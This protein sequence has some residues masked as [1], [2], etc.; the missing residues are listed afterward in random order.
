MSAGV[1]RPPVLP[2]VPR[3]E[4]RR[5]AER[6]ERRRRR[7]R[8]AGLAVLALVPLGVLAWL[9]LSSPLLQVRAVEVEGNRR[10][11]TAAVVTTAGVELGTALARVDTSAVRERVAALAPVADVEVH[12]TWP[13]T[14][15]VRVQERVGVAV[16]DAGVPGRWRLVD[17]TGTAFATVAER[18]PGL[19][20]LS[21]GPTGPAP[22]DRATSAGL[23][24]LGDLPAVLHERVETVTATSPTTVTLILDEG[25]TVVWGEAQDGARKAAVVQALLARRGRTL[26]VSSPDV[27]VVR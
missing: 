22:D 21:V 7:L 24:V 10:L 23:A 11:S 27:A 16:V 3:L 9:L 13:G 15:S 17:S 8:R 18:P 12:R 2:A 14:L 6:A 4:A 25:R 20:R 5:Q 1:Q 19:P 26:D